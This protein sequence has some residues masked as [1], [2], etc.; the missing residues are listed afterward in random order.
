M[1]RQRDEGVVDLAAY[2]GHACVGLLPTDHRMP[3]VD[4][5]DAAT[6][7]VVPKIALSQTR[8]LGVL[9]RRAHQRHMAWR[10]QAVGKGQQLSHCDSAAAA[11]LAATLGATR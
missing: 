7:A 9:A 4:R 5:V 2:V 10:K 1:S 8:V 11:T 6:V 3:R